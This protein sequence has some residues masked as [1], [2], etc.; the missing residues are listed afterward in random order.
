MTEAARFGCLIGAGFASVASIVS[1]DDD[2]TRFY[3]IDEGNDDIVLELTKISSISCESCC[4]DLTNLDSSFP[5]SACDT[6]CSAED[7][8]SFVAGDEKV[9]CEKGME[10]KQKGR[11]V[12]QGQ[13]YICRNGL[14]YHDVNL[15]ALL[16]ESPF[17]PSIPTP[18]SSPG[19]LSAV[20]GR[21]V[22]SAVLFS[23]AGS[24]TSKCES[25][26]NMAK[27]FM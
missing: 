14:T 27:L 1:P 8:S 9:A 3:C 2:S 5:A 20:D 7:C 4:T 16:T 11:M 22:A 13:N 6:G 10:I 18:A 19:I 17:S 15:D 25:K 24:M 21:I 26:S 12:F 23:L